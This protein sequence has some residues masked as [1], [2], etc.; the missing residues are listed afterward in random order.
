MEELTKYKMQNGIIMSLVNYINEIPPDMLRSIHKMLHEQLHEKKRIDN[1]QMYAMFVATDIYRQMMED[2]LSNR[3]VCD[4][5]TYHENKR[6]WYF[7]RKITF[8]K[9]MR[10]YFHSNRIECGLTDAKNL[11]ESMTENIE[12]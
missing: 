6:Y 7:P 10:D 3:R 4:Y 12:K 9:A 2:F 5:S 1:D 11:V 8:I